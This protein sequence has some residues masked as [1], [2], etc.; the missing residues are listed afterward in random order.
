METIYVQNSGGMACVGDDLAALAAEKIGAL[1][2][3]F[4]DRIP[5]GS[6]TVYRTN[7]IGD[8]FGV[9]RSEQHGRLCRFRSFNRT[10]AAA[11]RIAKKPG[12][13]HE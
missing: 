3:G 6:L 5:P 1:R 4:G 10:L 11:Q 7:E 8:W 9:R 13:T 2:Q 12:A